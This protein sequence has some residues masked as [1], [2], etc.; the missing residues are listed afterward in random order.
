MVLDNIYQFLIDKL[1]RIVI[2]KGDSN[3]FEVVEPDDEKSGK[4]RLGRLFY[5]NVVEGKIRDG[6]DDDANKILTMGIVANRHGASASNCVAEI[7]RI[8]LIN[9]MKLEIRYLEDII[10]NSIIMGIICE[11]LQDIPPSSKASFESKK[12]EIMS[13]YKEIFEYKYELYRKSFISYINELNRD[14]K[15]CMSDGLSFGAIIN[16]S[17]VE[18]LIE[19]KYNKKE[20]SGDKRNGVKVATLEKLE[21]MKEKLEELRNYQAVGVNKGNLDE[22]YVKLW[23]EYH[24]EDITRNGDGSKKAPLINMMVLPDIREDRDGIRGKK[25]EN[26]FYGRAR[27]QYVHA[28]SGI[29][30]SYMLRSIIVVC[31]VDYIYTNHLELMCEDE[32]RAYKDN[33]FSD[34]ERFYFGNEKKNRIPVYIKGANFN[35]YGSTDEKDYSEKN[36]LML[37]ENY[38]ELNAAFNF[39]SDEFLFLIDSLDEIEERN[40]N[41]FNV[42]LYNLIGQVCEK[43]PFIITSRF[44]GRSIHI[45]EM[46]YLRL[47]GFDKDAIHSYLRKCSFLDRSDELKNYIDNNKYAYELAKNPFMLTVML[48]TK[49]NFTVKNILD[50]ITE[51]IITRRMNQKVL[52]MDEDKIRAVLSY[53]AFYLSF[54]EEEEVIALEKIHINNII[55]EARDN[56]L[57]MS[58]FGYSVDISDEQIDTFTN[59]ISCQSG[60]I[61]LIKEDSHINFKFQDELVMCY[62]AAEFVNNLL[63]VGDDLPKEF[64]FTIKKGNT[65]ISHNVY[66][67]SR[68]WDN[69]RSKD[70]ILS[71]RFCQ[72][73]NLIIQI[74]TDRSYGIA[75]IY[76]ML[77]KGFT[78]VE[79]GMIKNIKNFFAEYNEKIYGDKE[80]FREEKDLRQ[81]TTLIDRL[82]E[83]FN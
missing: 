48:D 10:T 23:L 69:F 45:K 47:D 27:V 80:L 22:Y 72:I 6:S 74:T 49:S 9:D 83:I 37:S 8:M 14:N 77:L 2:V 17:I 42:C 57:L 24:M 75:L 34:I 59:T 5:A 11:D 29:G 55:K 51:A 16:A 64:Y 36:L 68:F 20:T 58:V 32:I 3:A 79:E 44:S 43:N 78:A 19:L 62:L 12:K 18:C 53:L 52:A 81:V 4:I 28:N 67:I 82:F 35:E 76:Y 7:F 1:G 61:T 33:K 31:I 40:V 38:N 66:E 65:A 30:K 50:K 46:E 15:F 26:P 41:N 21:K 63:R 71:K 54:C 56:G 39:L 13:S 70:S 73:I 25:L 60:I